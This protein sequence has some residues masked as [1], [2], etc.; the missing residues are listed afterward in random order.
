MLLKRV[1]PGPPKPVQAFKEYGED[2]VIAHSLKEL[3]AGMNQLV[4]DE[5]L[6][7]MHIKEQILARDR[8]IENTF[9][10]DAQVTAIHGARNYIG[11]K[12]N[13]CSKAT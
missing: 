1:L 2:F 6:D 13:S 11:D 4:G 3:V 9:T 7:F 5:L 10:K 12:L 8:E